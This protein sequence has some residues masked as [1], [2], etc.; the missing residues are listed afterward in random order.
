MVMLEVGGGDGVVESL[1]EGVGVAGGEAGGGNGV[2][3]DYEEGTGVQRIDVDG[4]KL[5]GAD[6]GE[7]DERDLG[8]DGHVRAAGHHGLE[9]AGGGAATFWEEDEGKAVFEGRYAA[10][11][12]GDQGAGTVGVDRNLTGTVEVPTD[13]RDLPE[14]LLGQDA[15]LEGETGEEDRGVHVA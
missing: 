10:V 12:A 1:G 3:D 8:F 5:V 13:E 15:E 9:L 4:E 6:E 2:A 14:G 11:E 7:R